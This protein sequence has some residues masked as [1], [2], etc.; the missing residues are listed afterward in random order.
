[1][2]FKE[3]HFRKDGPNLITHFNKQF[4][5]KATMPLGNLF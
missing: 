2:E 1:V 4:T 5:A 3:S